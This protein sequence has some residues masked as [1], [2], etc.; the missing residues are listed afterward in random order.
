MV[1]VRVIFFGFYYLFILGGEG[2][3]VDHVPTWLGSGLDFGLGP[4]PDLIQ[5]VLECPS[6]VCK[7]KCCFCCYH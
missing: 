7:C 1:R 2:G 3:G 5:N 4:V 6:V